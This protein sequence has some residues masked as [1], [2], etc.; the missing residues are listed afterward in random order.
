M[1]SFSQGF[2]L[3]K[4][5]MPFRLRFSFLTWYIGCLGMML[6][7]PAS[8]I[9]ILG[10]LAGLEKAISCPR[11]ANPLAIGRERVSRPRSF[12]GRVVKRNLHIGYNPPNRFTIEGHLAVGTPV[13]QHPPPRPGRA[14]FPHPVPRLYSLSRKASA[15]CKYPML[16]V[17]NYHFGF[18]NPQPVN[19]FA[20]HLPGKALS[21][22]TASVQPFK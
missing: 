6:S 7:N 9:S 5:E 18:G 8:E 13:T 1:P 15:L 19:G 3:M 22:S 14:V 21:L 12:H 2:D 10:A 4:R 17:Y 11:D 20:E 16:S